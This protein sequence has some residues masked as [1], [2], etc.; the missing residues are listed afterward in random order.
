[1]A[2]DVEIDFRRQIEKV[3]LRW[4]CNGAGSGRHGKDG[5]G[6]EDV[7]GGGEENVITRW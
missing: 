7:V 1:M 2:S 5:D 6:E 3:H 4:W